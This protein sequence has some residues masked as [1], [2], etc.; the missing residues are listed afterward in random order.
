MPANDPIDPSRGKLVHDLAAQ[1]G[2]VLRNVRLIEEL[3]A[4]RQRLVAAQ[5][6]ERR[7]LERNL[8]DGA[9]Q[10][11]VALAV[12]LRARWNSTAGKDPGHDRQLAAKLGSRRTHALEDLRDL[13]RGIYPPL[14]ADKGLGAALEAQARKAAVPTTVAA[15]GIERYPQDDRGGRLLLHA[16][17][18]EQRRQ[19][20]IGHARGHLV[21]ADR[22]SARR[23]RSATTGR[24]S[25]WSAHAT[26]PASRAWPTASMRSAG[27][28]RCAAFPAKAR[29]SADGCRSPRRRPDQGRAA[30]QA[31]SRRSGPNTALGMYAAAPHS[32]ARGAYSSSS[33]VESSNTTGGAVIAEDAT[34]RL[35]TVDPG[36]VH[37][38]QHEVGGEVG[39]HRDAVLPGL[40]LAD[41]FEPVGE[42]DDHACGEPERLLVVDDQHANWHLDLQFKRRRGPGG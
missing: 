37:V 16:R 11:L 4:S 26:G 10:Q 31:V 2:P 5:D 28:S 13:A 36:K 1:A 7:K 42:L 24:D 32:A 29:P 27:R 30:S 39:R 8:H 18:V 21:D 40:G 17:G 6:D 23:S 25:M 34:G 15:D 14:L 9:Q 38:H 12:Q 22:R 19:V 3:R 35:E 20:R 41:D 33:Y